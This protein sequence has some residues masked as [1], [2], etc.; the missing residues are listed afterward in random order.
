VST[1]KHTKITTICI[2][3]L[4]AA[5]FAFPLWYLLNNAF[6]LRKYIPIEPLKIRPETF[7]LSNVI[8]AFKYLRYPQAFWNSLI[9][10]ILSCFFL[11]VLGA[12][13]GYGIA[14]V[15][16]KM[17]ETVYRVF[18]VSITLPFT[19]AM[20]PVVAML[21]KLGLIDTYIAPVLIFVGMGI[22][23]SVFLY[24]GFMRTIPKELEEAAI[25]D[26]AGV[27]RILLTVYLPLLHGVTATLLVLR[28]V[29][30]WNDLL[31]PLL[32]LNSSRMLTLPYRLYAFAGD[33]LTYWDLIFAGTLLV[34][35]PIVAVFFIAQK[36]VT[37]GVLSGAIKG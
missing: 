2:T 12:L 23:F 8:S 16:S 3:G 26:G 30:I 21:G 29:G 7:T 24:T 4:I 22:P 5:V 25:M 6:K 31:I 20:V 1:R 9:I 32:T 13:A 18:V 36:Y 14:R 19:L 33:R 11:I 10:L 17:V 28:G 34:T 15:R 37:G 35:L 27:L